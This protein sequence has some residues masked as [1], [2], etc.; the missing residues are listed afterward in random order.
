[1]QMRGNGPWGFTL[2]PQLCK[3]FP[4][5]NVGKFGESY[6]SQLLHMDFQFGLG[7][8][9]TFSPITPTHSPH[10]SLVA[11]FVGSTT[12]M[13]RGVDVIIEQVHHW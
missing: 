12:V 5:E 6:G 10:L 8:T 9:I 1:M 4:K 7:K 2:T 13:Q 11:P 3:V